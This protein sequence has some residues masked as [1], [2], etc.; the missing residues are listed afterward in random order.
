[1]NIDICNKC[2]IFTDKLLQ[3]GIRKTHKVKAR[4][5]ENIGKKNVL[6]LAEAPGSDECKN[7]Q[8][9]VGRAGK[10]IDELLEKS[11]LNQ[12]NIRL[13]NVVKCRPI[14]M[15]NNKD[16][17]RTPTLDEINACYPYLQEDWNFN[18]DFIILL[19]K[20]ASK[21]IFPHKDPSFIR[22][23]GQI[24]NINNKDIAVLPTWHPAY[25]LRNPSSKDLLLKHF[26]N[27]AQ[28]VSLL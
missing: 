15:I 3:L 25:I 23:K 11:G 6:M 20:I 1:M 22:G 8:V 12:Y 27:V 24:L 18:P 13:S 9:L 21:A 14:E 28:F 5:I 4:V 19:G 2:P 26:I 17:N 16:K 10:L 7:N